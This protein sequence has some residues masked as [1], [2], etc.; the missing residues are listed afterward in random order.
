M[1]GIFGFVSK[2]GERPSLKQL[3]K[4]AT[5][6]EERGPHAFG[7]AWI[8]GSGRLRSFKQ[9]GRISR[10]LD[11]LAMAVD[12][13]M[14]IGHTRYATHGDPEN[15]SNNHPHPVDGGWLVHNGVIRNYRQLLTQWSMHP[16]SDCDSESLALLI[17]QLPG[18]L[19]ER[20][21]DAVNLTEGVLA[22]AAIWR[23]PQR[24][25]A[26][27]RGNPLALGQDD[28][29]WYFGSFARGLPGGQPLRDQRVLSFS[30]K[31]N[32]AKLTMGDLPELEDDE[33][34]LTPQP[35]AQSKKTTKGSQPRGGSPVQ[36]QF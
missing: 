32:I 27:R 31:G 8:D 15:N 33:P 5:I 9:Q 13:R 16:V 2:S 22:M 11:L 28:G 6:T 19:V 20:C 25:V 24:L 14:L 34:Q 23:S 7:F 12:A 29:G 4:I 36:F 3:Q 10:S 35:A 18:T 17:E 1:C 26:I 21:Q 30:R